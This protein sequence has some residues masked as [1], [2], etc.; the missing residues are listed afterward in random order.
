MHDVVDRVGLT[1]LCKRMVSGQQLVK[2]RTEREDV[3]AVVD[4][5]PL[6]LLGRHVPHRTDVRPLGSL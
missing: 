5:V 6:D 2:D 1:R 4:V 3:G